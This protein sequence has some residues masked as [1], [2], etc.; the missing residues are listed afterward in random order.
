VVAKEIVRPQVVPFLCKKEGFLVDDINNPAPENI[1]SPLN[2]NNLDSRSLRVYYSKLLKEFMQIVNYGLES[3]IYP[4]SLV[5]QLQC[6]SETIQHLTFRL[7]DL[8]F[9]T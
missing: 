7:C 4:R 5:N 6:V 9:T 2:N 8:R 1:P 3:Y